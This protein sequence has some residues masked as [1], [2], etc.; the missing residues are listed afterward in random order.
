[1][2]LAGGKLKFI[3]MEPVNPLEVPNGSLFIDET[4]LNAITYKNPSGSSSSL[5]ETTAESLL[6]KQMQSGA[7]S[8]PKNAP[9]AKLSNGKV[10]QAQSDGDQAFIGFSLQS[11]SGVDQL[12]NVLLVGANIEG[13][14][15]GLGF[16]PGQDVL[17]GE[18]GEYVNSVSGF[19]GNDD[20][21]IK[22]GIAD[23]A[24]GVA[25]PVATDL[26]V[27]SDVIARP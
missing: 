13:A 12:L 15:S 24:A 4:N 8:I 26:V 25:S 23:C 2:S 7:V 19:T 1:M 16:I 18:S 5:T 14:V 22:I 10:V 6:I 9:L 20:S 21:I 17:L 3:Q 27:F 11:V